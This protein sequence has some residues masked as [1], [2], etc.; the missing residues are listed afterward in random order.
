MWLVAEDKQPIYAAEVYS[1]ERSANDKCL[2]LLCP[3]KRILQRADSLNLPT[4]TVVS[5]PDRLAL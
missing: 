5:L 1:I 2:T 4:L 3:T